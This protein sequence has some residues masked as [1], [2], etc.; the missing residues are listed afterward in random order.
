MKCSRRMKR[1]RVLW[2]SLLSGVLMWPA[3]MVAHAEEAANSDRYSFDQVVVTATKNPEKEFETNANISVITKEKIEKNQY[4]NLAEAL[5]SV[6][7]VNIQ[8]YG[9]GG[10]GYTS[11][12][13]YINGSSNVVVLI[14]GIRAN[15]NGTVFNKFPVAEFNALNNIERIEV[16]KGSASTLYG[17]DAQGGVINIITR[18]PTS[19][20]TTL[21]LS[22]GSYGRGLY[23][24][25]TQ[26]SD[27]GFSWYIA[28][29]K[30]TIGDNK[31]AKGVTIPTYQDAVTNT[32][33]LSKKLND[34]SDLS[35][36]FQSYY[37]NYMRSGPLSNLTNVQDGKKDNYKWNVVYNYKLSDR[38]TNQLTIFQNV[39]RLNDSYNKVSSLWYMDL[40]TVGF[41]DQFTTKL[42]KAHLLTSGVDYYQDKIHKYISNSGT[43]TTYN[44][45]T[46]S[47]TAIYVQDEWDLTKA[48]KL[49]S[50]V[51]MD[52]HSV[53]HTHTTPSVTLGYKASEKTNY[54]IGYREYFVSPNQAQLYSP[55][56]GLPDGN[57]NLK[58]ETGHT[59]EA[60]VRHRF[61]DGFS[62]SINAFVRNSKNVIKFVTIDSSMGMSTRSGRYYNQALE[63]ARGLEFRLDKRF[64]KYFSV[65]AG[66]TYTDIDR[67]SAKENENVNGAI[68]KGVWNLGLNYT[69]N[70]FDASL[71]G[72]GVINRFGSLSAANAPYTDKYSNYWVWDLALNYKLSPQATLFVKANNIFNEYYTELSSTLNPT[73]WYSSPG[74][75]FQVGIEYQ[76]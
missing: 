8:T 30:Q 69:K 10:E 55:Q 19:N 23:S 49:T 50:G 61:S 1:K 16:L 21:K 65:Y 26:G 37:A 70:K 54:F 41:Q 24:I 58:P 56:Y 36:Y 15:V 68:P 51:R 25:S 35:F 27:K 22:G 3:T 34:V 59:Y 9:A 42:G 71:V 20:K 29:Q 60:G 38:T 12:T 32:L 66:F 40:E 64:D 46:V 28:S 44:G 73:K 18:K 43:P 72:R 11:N 13:L 53:Y 62:G 31:D 63:N 52:F 74:R 57:P 17:S 76:F 2:C 45:K 7:G 47:D 48:W 4:Q 5:K 67:A 39:N 33:K 14:D 75:N 6:P